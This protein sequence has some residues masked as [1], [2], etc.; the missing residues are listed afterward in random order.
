MRLLTYNFPK[1]VCVVRMKVSRLLVKY[2]TCVCVTPL[3]FDEF[4]PFYR[5]RGRSMTLD[6]DFKKQSVGGR[7]R[8]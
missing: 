5:G 8:E 3:H 2:I 6:P 7:G 1:H 4:L